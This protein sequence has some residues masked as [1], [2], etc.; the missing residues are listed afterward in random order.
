MGKE[1]YCI[2]QTALKLPFHWCL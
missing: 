2:I 1:M